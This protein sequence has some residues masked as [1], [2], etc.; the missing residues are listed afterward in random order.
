MLGYKDESHCSLLKDFYNHVDHIFKCV[1]YDTGGKKATH[2]N[3]VIEERLMKLFFRK[4]CAGLKESKMNDWHSRESADLSTGGLN[5]WTK[6]SLKSRENSYCSTELRSS[7]EKHRNGKS[8]TYQIP[9]SYPPFPGGK[10]DNM[11]FQTSDFL[12][13][14]IS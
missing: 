8:V 12:C 13:V 14:S 4:L 1:S 3:R 7:A 2:S 9:L 6:Q 5:N 10:Y 11:L